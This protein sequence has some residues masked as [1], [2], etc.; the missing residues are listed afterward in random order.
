M[1]RRTLEELNGEEYRKLVKR[2]PCEICV[3]HFGVDAEPAT[4]C[5]ADAHHPRTG[6]GAGR[7]NSDFETISLCK[8][9]HQDSASAIHVLGRKAFERAFGVTEAQ[10]SARTRARVIELLSRRV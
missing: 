6:A 3:M 7:K 4:D 2:L 10:L 8:A 5:V 9:H 1:I